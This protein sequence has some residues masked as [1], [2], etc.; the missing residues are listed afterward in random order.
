MSTAKRNWAAYFFWIG[1]VA[2]LVCFALVLGGNTEALWRFER[3]SFPLS[4][5]FAGAAALAFVGAEYFDKAR[6]EV[7]QPVVRRPQYAP[8]WVSP[9]VKFEGEAR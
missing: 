5:V 3:R 9:G 1:V 8:E 7:D 6:S 2:A 4:W